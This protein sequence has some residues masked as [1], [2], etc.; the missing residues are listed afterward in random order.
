MKPRKTNT[1]LDLKQPSQICN[2]KH[3]PFHSGF[4]L[5]KKSFK[6]VIIKK[7]FH[8]TATI[9]LKRLH[10]LRKYERYEKRR[11]RLKVHNPPCIDAKIGDIV[12]AYESRPISKT[13][14]FVIVD[15]NESI[16]S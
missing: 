14:N 7:D 10:K 6:G 8:K 15:K 1:G 12:T 4:K 13:K 5:K 2:D 11:T 16:K 3:C 9:E